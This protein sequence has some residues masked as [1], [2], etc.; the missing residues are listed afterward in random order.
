MLLKKNLTF[1]ALILSVCIFWF[2]RDI[3]S[4]L[5]YNEG[6]SVS[7][8]S[9][10]YLEFKE[11][12]TQ[13]FFHFFNEDFGYYWLSLILNFIG[14]NFQFLLFCVLFLYYL[15]FLLIFY[16]LSGIKKWYVYLFLFLGLSLWMYPLVTVAFR[17]GIAFLIL[18]SL[19]FRKETLPFLSKLLIIIL[20]SAFHFSAIF[21]LPYIFLDKYLSNR[22]KILDIFFIIVFFLYISGYTVIISN[23]FINI[24]SSLSIDIRALANNEL[25][26]KTGFSIYKAL[27]ILIPAL[28][29][30]MSNLSNLYSSIL[31]GRI[32][33][34][35]I[36]VCICG[37]ILSD[38][39]Y[40]DRILLYGWGISPIL[41][42][43]FLN[44]FLIWLSKIYKHY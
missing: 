37:M 8:L 32:Y 18:I 31:A 9:R 15:S 3:N 1:I 22:L 29:F 12:E 44:T 25:L 39:P 42:C 27:A 38:L 7:D 26:Y 2:I 5:I 14:I 10:Y 17:Q 20:A 13:T 36:F 19:L 40:H 41:V 34:F 11:T 6:Y 35:Y 33:V 16:K 24:T 28:L 30:R 4:L 23:L 21:L 43:C